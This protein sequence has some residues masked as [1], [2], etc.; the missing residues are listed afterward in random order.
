VCKLVFSTNG[1]RIIRNPYAKIKS[2]KAEVWENGSG[3]SIPPESRKEKR[4]ARCSGLY[5]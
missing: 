2:R 4:G 1:V 5:L 3:G